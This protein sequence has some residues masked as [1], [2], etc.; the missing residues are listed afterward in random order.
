MLDNVLDESKHVTLDGDQNMIHHVF[1]QH[2]E[3]GHDCHMSAHL[4]GLNSEEIFMLD[5]GSTQTPPIFNIH[6]T[7]NKLPPPNKPPRA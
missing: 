5:L 7:N 6:Y 1:D 2:H 3:D 4:V